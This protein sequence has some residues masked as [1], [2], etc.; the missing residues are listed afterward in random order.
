MTVNEYENTKATV[1][2]LEDLGCARSLGAFIGAKRRLQEPW[3]AEQR[4]DLQ[5]ARTLGVLGQVPG[6]NAQ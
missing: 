1:H 6:C 3:P 5:L 2:Y 4:G